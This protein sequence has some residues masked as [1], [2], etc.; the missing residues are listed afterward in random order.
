MIDEEVPTGGGTASFTQEG[1]VDITTHDGSV[2]TIPVLAATQPHQLPSDCTILLGQP[3]LNQLSVSMNDHMRVRGLP[4]VCRAAITA[5]DP[6]SGPISP[7]LICYSGEK[8][9]KKWFDHNKHMPVHHSAYPHKHIHMRAECHPDFDPAKAPPLPSEVVQVLLD[10]N[11]T[12][13]TVF[14]ADKRSLPKAVDHPPV[15]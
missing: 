5:E 11:T 8:D 7:A 4:L 14:D 1:L 9:L 15:N 10:I 2:A 12:F 3:Q 6:A 13:G